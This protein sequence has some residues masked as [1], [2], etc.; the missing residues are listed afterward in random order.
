MN[1]R[2]PNIF[3]Q[4]TTRGWPLLALAVASFSLM[5]TAPLVRGQGVISY[6]QDYYGTVAPT[7]TAG[8]ERFLPS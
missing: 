8:V 5:G 1:N 4:T 3:P 7:A 6:N 2:H